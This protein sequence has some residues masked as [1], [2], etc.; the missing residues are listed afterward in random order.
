MN[1]LIYNKKLTFPEFSDLSVLPDIAQTSDLQFKAPQ[2]P[3]V[4][5]MSDYGLMRKA[6]QDAKAAGVAQMTPEKR[7]H[8]ASL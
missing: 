2:P 1:Q 7:A 4:G 5:T 6:T 3:D 8:W